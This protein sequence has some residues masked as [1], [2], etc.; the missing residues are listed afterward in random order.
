MTVISDQTIQMEAFEY[1][2]TLLDSQCRPVEIRAISIDKISSP[3]GKIDR[4]E[5][6]RLFGIND[7]ELTRP[8][9]G[10]IDVLIGL[11]YAAYHPDRIAAEGH[12]LLY[13]NRFGK[14]VGGRH[15]SLHEMTQI[16]KACS[17]VQ[18]A[19]VMHVTGSYDN[20]QME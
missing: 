8:V 2:V 16:S 20:S 6:C 7:I 9:E 19:V 18:S 12:L 15:P 1:K 17:Q 4:A 13:E 5:V 14:T 10:E 11:E 3:I